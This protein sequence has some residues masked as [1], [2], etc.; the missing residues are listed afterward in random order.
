MKS[1][2]AHVRAALVL[3]HLTMIFVIAFPAPIGGMDRSNWKVASVQ[4][5]FAAWATLLHVSA[6]SLEDAIYDLA[7]LYMRGRDAV[8]SPFGPYLRFSGCDQPWRMFVAPVRN[9]AKLQVQLHVRGAGPDTWET[10]FEEASAEHQ[11]H[12]L[13]FE[14]ERLRSQMARWWWPAFRGVFNESC[15]Y[16]AR[17]AFAERVDA[18]Q[19][20][21]RYSLAPSLTP[22][23][24]RAGVVPQVQYTEPLVH[25]RP[26]P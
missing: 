5:D 20:R 17:L 23:Q 14:Q 13:M 8:A 25:A 4:Q 1:L 24:A 22:E 18:D 2:W 7:V 19:V 16:F 21:C 6:A 9:I 3:F 10:L 11:W 26:P 12:K 15:A